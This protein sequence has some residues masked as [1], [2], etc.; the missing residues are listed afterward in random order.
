LS[1]IKV[2]KHLIKWSNTLLLN[3]EK[4]GREGMGRERNECE[5]FK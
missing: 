5:V 2:E 4:K 3:G 1:S